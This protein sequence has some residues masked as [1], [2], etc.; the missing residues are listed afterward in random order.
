HLS[1]VSNI[2]VASIR[3]ALGG[4]G[5]VDGKLIGDY[6]IPEGAVI[7]IISKTGGGDD[8]SEAVA[9]VDADNPL[10]SVL[11]QESAAAMAVDEKKEEEEVKEQLPPPPSSTISEDGKK[12]LLQEPSVFRTKLR[13]LVYKHFKQADAPLQHH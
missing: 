12:L 8:V 5:M 4:K 11:N 10:S 6:A 9:P 2:P 1:R 3:L 7:Q 13:E